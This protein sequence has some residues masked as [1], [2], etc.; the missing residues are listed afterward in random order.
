MRVP[1]SLA[2]GTSQHQFFPASINSSPSPRPHLVLLGG[3]QPLDA[4][5]ESHAVIYPSIPGVKGGV[6]CGEVEV[7]IETINKPSWD[8]VW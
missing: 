5:E 1:Y 6:Q 8:D 7:G 2:D 3:R 4:Q